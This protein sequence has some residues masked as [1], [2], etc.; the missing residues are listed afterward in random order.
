MMSQQN[1]MMSPSFAQHQHLVLLASLV[2]LCLHRYEKKGYNLIQMLQPLCEK[3][4]PHSKNYKLKS[5]FKMNSQLFKFN[6]RVPKT[7]VQTQIN[8][9]PLW[10]SQ[11]QIVSMW[12]TADPH[13]YYV[14]RLYSPTIVDF[15]STLV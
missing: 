6:T 14:L 2:S 7:Q 3:A 11:V 8:V 12:H 10:T 9:N 5:G 4:N 13:L 15:E 1:L